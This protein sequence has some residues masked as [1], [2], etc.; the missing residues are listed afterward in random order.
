MN[1]VM[2]KAKRASDLD[3][4]IVL[5]KKLKISVDWVQSKSIPK[6]IE[7]A[8]V[9]VRNKKTPVLGC[10][11]GKMWFADDFDAPLDDFEEYV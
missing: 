5:A 2:L 9:S 10:A 6:T 3:I 4:F 8:N 1:A 11:K 7:K